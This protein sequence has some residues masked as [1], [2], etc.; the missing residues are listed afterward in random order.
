MRWCYRSRSLYVGDFYC[1]RSSYRQREEKLTLIQYSHSLAFARGNE[2]LLRP[3][4]GQGS[5]RGTRFVR[6]S[7]GCFLEDCIMTNHLSKLAERIDRLKRHNCRW[8]SA[9]VA[10]V[11][12]LRP[13][14]SP[15]SRKRIAA[16]RTARRQ[17]FSPV[18]RGP[19]MIRFVAV[20]VLCISRFSRCPMTAS[21]R[22]AGAR[23]A[24]AGRVAVEAVGA[25][26][27]EAGRGAAEPV[28]VREAAEVARP[29]AGPRVV[30]AP[31]PVPRWAAVPG[32]APRGPLKGA[33]GGAR[34]WPP[35]PAV[36]AL[37][38]RASRPPGRTPA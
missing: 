5:A 10:I 24:E 25:R 14:S 7:T 11:A 26:G 34:R 38:R 12:L 33:T 28:P 20:V 29:G 21:P 22:G 31:R 32:L 27:A 19:I 6:K 17:F 3:E 36:R 37:V 23:E 9:M 30:P 16:S 13:A 35:A 8:K 4:P 2:E 15:T 1:T 18:S